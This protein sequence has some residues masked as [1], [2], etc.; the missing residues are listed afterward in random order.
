MEV[1]QVFQRCTRHAI[2]RST[3]CS[4]PILSSNT[5][6][7]PKP[8]VT[9]I[10]VSQRH[11]SSSSPF[12]ATTQKPKG[13]DN[14]RQ[15]LQELL[16]EFKKDLRAGT[17]ANERLD[18]LMGNPR[19]TSS[20]SSSLDAF[21][22][23][24]G[25][26]SP[27]GLTPPRDSELSLSS[28]VASLNQEHID[29]YA[30]INLRLKPSLGRTVKVMSGD[31][32]RAFQMLERKCTQNNIRADVRNQ[33]FHVRKGMKVKILRMQRWRALFREGFVAECDQIRRMRKQGW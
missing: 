30:D 5:T 17:P 9:H 28:F 14:G 31:P 15:S 25:G 6:L 11:A 20:S 12:T 24:L 19:R 29:P 27:S 3:R 2:H 18:A 32:G 23:T 1:S 26:G 7:K 22:D 13:N 33:R 4:I 16:R 8:Q 21:N 10:R